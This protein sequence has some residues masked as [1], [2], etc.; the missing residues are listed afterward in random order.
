MRTLLPLAADTEVK[1]PALSVTPVIPVG[2]RAI[3]RP[4]LELEV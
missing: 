3:K 2:T 1:K 4:T